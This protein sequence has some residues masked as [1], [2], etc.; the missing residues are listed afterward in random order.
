MVA[1][2]LLPE[3]ERL[4]M[5]TELCYRLRQNDLLYS[6]ETFVASDLEIADRTR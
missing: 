2:V 5:V 3:I 6:G 1:A 4:F